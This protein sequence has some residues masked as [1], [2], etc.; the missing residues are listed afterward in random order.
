L[1]VLIKCTRGVGHKFNMFEAC[2]RQLN[3]EE[4]VKAESRVH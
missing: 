1:L 3:S 4:A 2:Q